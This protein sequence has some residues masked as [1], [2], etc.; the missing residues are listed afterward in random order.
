MLPVT[1]EGW[2]CHINSSWPETSPYQ[3]TVDLHQ[4]M[5]GKMQSNALS[6]VHN[7]DKHCLIYDIIIIKES[8][9]NE[10]TQTQRGKKLYGKCR[11]R[12]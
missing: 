4:N 5:Q 7:E 12:V 10:T 8:M 1:E 3:M 6:R 2:T 11:K 9:A